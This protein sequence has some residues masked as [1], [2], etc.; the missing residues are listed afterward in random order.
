M[1][2]VLAVAAAAASLTAQLGAAEAAPFSYICTVQ[3]YHDPEGPNDGSDWLGKMAMETTVAIDRR[4]G[5]II[6][7]VLGNTGYRKTTV[8]DFGGEEWSFKVLSESGHLPNDPPIGGNTLY[9]EVEEF[10]EGFQKP[11]VAIQGGTAYLGYCD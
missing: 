9:V 8:L 5:A 3:S 4:T 11:F 1:K 6:H 10:D 2:T 7:P